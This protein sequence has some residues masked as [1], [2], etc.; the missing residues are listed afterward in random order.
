MLGLK[1]AFSWTLSKAVQE[2]APKV[3]DH[4]WSYWTMEQAWAVQWP[5]PDSICNVLISYRSSFILVYLNLAMQ[6][7][8]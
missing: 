7:L 8:H 5:H 3:K 2:N 6:Y 4:P 1:E